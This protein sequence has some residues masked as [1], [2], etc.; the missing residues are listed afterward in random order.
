LTQPKDR[1][2][3]FRTVVSANAFER[4]DT[5]MQRVCEERRRAP[6]FPVDD[7]AVFPDLLSVLEHGAPRAEGAGAVPPSA[8]YRADNNFRSVL[9]RGEVERKG[10][11]VTG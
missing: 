3:A 9:G 5:V 1:R 10:H 11:N 8:R 4:P 2:L 6:G 7:F